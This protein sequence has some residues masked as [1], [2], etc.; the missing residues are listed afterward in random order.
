MRRA[1]VWVL[2]VLAS[3]VTSFA[4]AQATATSVTGNVTAQVGTGPTRAIIQGDTVRAGET[5]NTASASAVVLRY[6]DG[7]ITSLTQ[8]SKFHIQ[9]YEYNPQTKS[10]NI[11]LELLAGGVRTV[12]G[13]IAA[14]NPSRF[15]MKAGT[16]TIGIRGTD[17]IAGYDAKQGTVVAVLSG[18]VIVSWNG[19]DLATLKAGEA[20]FVKL[21]GTFVVGPIDVIFNL[22]PPGPLLAT[23]APFV[24]SQG[25]GPSG[26]AGGSPGPNVPGGAGG[27]GGASVR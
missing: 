1:I 6:P 21:D 19:K 16:T 13:L 4:F 9:A 24:H 15:A 17:F 23:L 8:N 12:S 5:I 14:T 11:L 27:G 20:I 7:Q 3:F 25:Q 26:G 18:S 2:G 10:G 22:L